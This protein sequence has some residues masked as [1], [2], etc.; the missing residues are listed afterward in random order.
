MDS[1]YVYFTSGVNNCIISL[2]ERLR[3]KDDEWCCGLMEIYAKKNFKDPLYLCSD[4]WQTSFVDQRE[5]PVISRVTRQPMNSHVTYTHIK[6]DECDHVR[7]YF[8]GSNG[9]VSTFR[10]QILHGTLHFQRMRK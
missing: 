3:F 4:I 10:D 1:F 9:Q 2:A 5:L 7:L 6:T 8:T